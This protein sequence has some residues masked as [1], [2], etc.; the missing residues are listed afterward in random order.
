MGGGGEHEA[1]NSSISFHSASSGA[2][3][4]VS[5][6]AIRSMIEVVDIPSLYETLNV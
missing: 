6:R 5:G 1:A 3:R 2:R 4:R